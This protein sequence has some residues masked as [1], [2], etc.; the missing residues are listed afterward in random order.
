MTYNF[1]LELKKIYS[2]ESG[3]PVD[4]PDFWEKLGEYR[5]KNMDEELEKEPETC[6]YCGQEM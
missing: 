6:P 5:D 1:K 4:S 2:K 3:I